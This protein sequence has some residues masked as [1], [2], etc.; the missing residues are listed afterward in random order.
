MEARLQNSPMRNS[1]LELFRIITMLIIVAHHY[2]VSP[3]FRPLVFDNYPMMKSLFLMI[4]GCGGKTGINC[5]VLITGYYMCT[6][7]ITLRKFLKLFLPYYFYKVFFLI[8]FAVT[9][10][11]QITPVFIK[12]SLLPISSVD[13]SF[14]NCYLLF[15]LFIP[16]LNILVKGLN[17]KQYQFLL[18]V[19]L[20]IFSVLPTFLIK[21][22]YSYVSWFMVVYLIGAY[23]RLYPP[24]WSL[25]KKKLTIGFAVSVFLSWLSVWGCAHITYVFHKSFNYFFISDS[26]KPLA[27]ITA[28][29]AF[30]F[31]KNL[32]IKNSKIINTIAASTFGVLL[33]HANS[34]VMRNWLWHDVID[35]V[36][37][38]EGNVYFHAIISVIVVYA[39]CTFIDFIRI[40]ILEKPFFKLF[41]RKMGS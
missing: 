35:N 24:Q 23:L 20:F 36:G 9:G 4:F 38:F 28:M 34:A 18:G 39:T 3:E 6:S 1:N 22:N 21:V 30:L 12:N 14:I 19:S 37:H 40:Q 26:N 5:F 10:F 25:C 7:H 29:F 8:F 31:F 16:F 2:V 13:H 32:K 17:K 33:I 41:D 27:I 15:F 11:A